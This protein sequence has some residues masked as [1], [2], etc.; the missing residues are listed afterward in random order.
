V[1]EAQNERQQKLKRPRQRKILFAVSGLVGVLIVA[2]VIVAVTRPAPATTALPPAPTTRGILNLVSWWNQNH[3]LASPAECT[4]DGETPFG[5]ERAWELGSNAIACYDDVP[6]DSWQHKMTYVDIYF[7][8]KA[9][10]PQAIAIARSVL[11]AD[12]ESIGTYDG[13]NTTPS[14]GTC[15]NFV[16]TSPTLAAA[17]HQTSPTWTTNP[18]N[19][20]IILYSGHD[21]EQSG[22][23][24]TYS[25]DSVNVAS[26]AIGAED[27]GP[28]GETYC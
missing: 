1:S 25:P 21:D 3:K 5:T 27:H 6:G 4:R 2:G 13:V 20:T 18:S 11:P 7:P 17:V 10:E 9:T 14:P 12:A 15:R 8:G 23:D 24:T 28:D 19:A 26:V 22:S 16:Y